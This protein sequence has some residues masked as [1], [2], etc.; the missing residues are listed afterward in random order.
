MRDRVKKM[1]IAKV[2]S[3]TQNTEFFVHVKAS[4]SVIQIKKSKYL[5]KFCVMLVFKLSFILIDY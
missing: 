3:I 1:I 5:D 4:L 2:I